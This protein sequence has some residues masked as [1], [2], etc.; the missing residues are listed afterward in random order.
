MTQIE[1]EKARKFGVHVLKLS[2]HKNKVH[3]Y[4]HTY[5]EHHK[6]RTSV[7]KL[8]REKEVYI[9]AYICILERMCQ[10]HNNKQKKHN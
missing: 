10:M 9:Y 5:I 3:D 1:E 6:E 7:R 4:I 2:Q 8:T